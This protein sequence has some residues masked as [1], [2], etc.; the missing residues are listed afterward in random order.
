MSR[1]SSGTYSVPG[2]VNPVITNTEITTN[3]ANTTLADVAQGITDSLDRQ[4][5][6]SMLAALKLI[7]GALGTPALTFTNDTT[8]G[9]TR[10]AAGEFS[11]GVAGVETITYQAAVTTF[12]VLASFAQAQSTYVPA[13][14]ADL[15]NKLYADNLSFSTSLPGQAGNSGKFVRTNGTAA[16]WED[17]DGPLSTTLTSN[18]TLVPRTSYRVDSSGGAFDLQ[19]PALVADAWIKITD[20][21]GGLGTN[22]VTVIPNGTDKIMNL[23]ENLILD[24]P[25]ADIKL[26]GTTARGWVLCA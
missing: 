3:W 22:A 17:Y 12:P 16:S 4:G 9:L 2:T 24:I 1:N 7:D 26:R 14:A 25:Y 11:T 10:L 8:S 6:G 19:L 15:V 21:S 18:T 13:V 20:V 23:A 5:R